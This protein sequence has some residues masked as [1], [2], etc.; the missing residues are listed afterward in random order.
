[1]RINFIK[2]KALNYVS[3]AY[4]EDY[5]KVIGIKLEL[6]VIQSILT[7]FNAK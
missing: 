5:L 3:Y 1:M 6:Y 7:K 4:K 2:E